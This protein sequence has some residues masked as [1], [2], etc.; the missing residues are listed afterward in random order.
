LEDSADGEEE[1]DSSRTKVGGVKVHV[2]ST[3]DFCV[4][5]GIT[6]CL[7]A[8]FV[9]SVLIRSGFPFFVIRHQLTSK[10]VRC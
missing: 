10:K 1:N 9:S 6:P 7:A 3:E 4:V 5:L 8:Y 2:H